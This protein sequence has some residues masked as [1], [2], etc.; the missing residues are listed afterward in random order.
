M[1][2]ILSFGRYKDKMSH[3]EVVLHDPERTCEEVCE[4]EIGY[5]ISRKQPPIEKMNLGEEA[6][7]GEV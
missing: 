3:P 4:T 7:E 6:H 2:S 5:E 1:W